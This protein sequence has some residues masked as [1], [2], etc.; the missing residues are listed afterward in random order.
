M[1]MA[2]AYAVFANGG[3]LVQPQLITKLVD[4][5]GRKM[6]QAPRQELGSA[7]APR[8][9]QAGN[10]FLVTHMMQDVIRVGTGAA[11]RA[12]GRSDLAGKTGTTSSFRDA[13][14]DGFNHDRGAIAWVGFNQPRSLGSGMQGASVALP[15]WMQYMR[16]AV[17]HDPDTPWTA[18]PD[19]VQIPVNPA[20]GYAAIGNSPGST[21]A[22]F[23]QQFPPIDPSGARAAL[24]TAA[25]PA[26]ATGSTPAAA[27][28]GS[29]FVILPHADPV[30]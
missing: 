20:T 21:M 23:L 17:Q 22:W 4:A 28:G 1:Q 7:A 16:G 13:W 30:H 5:R 12:L 8:I 24:P 2:R 11:A 10:A 25:P 27:R 19:V 9:L 6:D 14:F 26:Q 15:I 3:Y 18:P 29:P